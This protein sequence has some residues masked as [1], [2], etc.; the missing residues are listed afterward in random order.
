MSGYWQDNDSCQVSFSVPIT[1]H[2]LF[3]G[4][5]VAAAA[6]HLPV[7]F[8]RGGVLEDSCH[9]QCSPP[10]GPQL[11]PARCSFSRSSECGDL[12][13]VLHIE[14]TMRTGCFFRLQRRSLSHP[15][16]YH[17]HGAA[18]TLFVNSTYCWVDCC[19]DPQSNW[20]SQSCPYLERSVRNAVPS[21]SRSISLRHCSS[22]ETG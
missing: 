9:N 20:K 10:G 16:C 12:V 4:N 2:S 17:C 6:P 21:P 5:L 18:L 15:G 8:Q 13:L 19:W 14:T 7:N 22:Q 1:V 3:L 11:P